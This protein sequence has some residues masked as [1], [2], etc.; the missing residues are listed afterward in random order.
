MNNIEN[1]TS[2]E[3]EQICRDTGYFKTFIRWSNF[4]GYSKDDHAIYRCGF[5]DTYDSAIGNLYVWVVDGK[6]KCDF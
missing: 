4:V 2:K 1:L 5:S 3:L 6:Y